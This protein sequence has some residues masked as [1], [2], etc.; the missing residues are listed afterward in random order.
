MENKIRIVIIDDHPLFRE[1]VKN[2]LDLEENIEVVGQGS[3][4]DEA[5]KIA[6]HVL[7]DIIILDINMPGNGIKT[8]EIISN[9]YPV[10]KIV[11]LTGSE[12]EDSVLKAFKAGAKA[13]IL[14]GVSASELIGII[15]SVYNG[16]V[17]VTPILAASLIMDKS[18]K[19]TKSDSSNYMNDLNEREHQILE[20]VASGYSNKE[21]G[22]KIFLS[23]KTIKHYMTNILQKL[24]VRN[25]VEAALL[26]YKSGIGKEKNGPPD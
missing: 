10:I 23:E 14:K 21:V 24:H 18:G 13:Y 17:Y 12:E 15:N 19:N 11:M 16:E 5:L 22:E 4:S 7:P 8:A 2:I 6:R 26:A 20:L 1:G 25:R 3:T 9:E